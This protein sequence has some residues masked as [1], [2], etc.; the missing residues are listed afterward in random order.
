MQ[1]L[2]FTIRHYALLEKILPSAYTISMKILF[3]GGGTAGHVTPN[4]ALIE[5]LKDRAQCY[6]AGTDGMEYSLIKPLVQQGAV[7]QY[8]TIT[9]HKLQRRLT[10]S[11]LLLPVRLMQSVKQ[12]KEFLR[13]LRPDVVFSKGGYVGLPVIIAAHKL[14]IATIIHESDMTMGLANKL[15][16]RYADRLLA[17]FPCHPRAE[18]VG[19]ILRPS[20]YNGDKC[21]GRQICGNNDNR[22]QLLVVGG[23]LGAL[24]LN[25]LIKQ[26]AP[27]LSKRFHIFVITGKDKRIDSPY[28]HQ[29]QYCTNINDVYKA[30]DIC[31]TRGGSN[32]LAELTALNIPFAV[33]PLQHCSRGE[34][35][36]NAQYFATKGCGV[37]IEENIS[38]NQLADTLNTLYDN[39][40]QYRTAQR[41]MVIDGTNTVAD[42]L[43]GYDR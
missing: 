2:R 27:Q 20:L 37:V 40:E 33:L 6:Y 8:F 39:A 11:N 19:A 12:A 10:P 22:P 24:Q 36:V 26:C 31:L 42:I 34:Q 1:I 15:S 9:A 23:S 29:E 14:K 3:T 21:K 38:P 35:V 17:T 13:T 25:Q 16:A 4:I 32:A 18:K 28:V 30:T 43:M 5:L 7:R 41:K